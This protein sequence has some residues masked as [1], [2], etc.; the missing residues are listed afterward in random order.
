DGD[1][2]GEDDDWDADITASSSKTT[3]VSPTTP[4]SAEPLSG[5]T[6][7][8]MA[9]TSTTKLSATTSPAPSHVPVAK[10]SLKLS[11]PG[12]KKPGPSGTNTTTLTTGSSAAGTQ[13]RKGLGA[14]KLGGGAKS[15]ALPDDLF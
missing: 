11:K 12:L 7:G 4:K 2:W 15:P 8:G 1:A 10:T 3:T 13:R 5:R 6:S 9:M 14:M